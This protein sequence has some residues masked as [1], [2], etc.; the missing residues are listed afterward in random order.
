MKRGCIDPPNTYQ[1]P[2]PFFFD[3]NFSEYEEWRRKIY[4][5]ETVSPH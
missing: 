2:L 3:G 1:A 5:E 4:G